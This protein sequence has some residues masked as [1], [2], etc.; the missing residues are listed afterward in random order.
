MVLEHAT[1]LTERFASLPLATI[2]ESCVIGLWETSQVKSWSEMASFLNP[3]W[4]SLDL[5]RD[6]MVLRS[7]FEAGLCK[8]LVLR[9]VLI[10]STGQTDSLKTFETT[11][12]WMRD[13]Q[14]T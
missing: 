4:P 14:L 10:T 8:Q 1:G 13:M 11:L 6:S 7:C 3:T 9:A 12:K 2:F 5:K